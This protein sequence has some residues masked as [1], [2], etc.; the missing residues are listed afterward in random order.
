MSTKCNL[1]KACVLPFSHFNAYPMG[2]AR[3]CTM[4]GIFKDIDLNKVSID[5][6]FNSEEY[7]KLRS[8]MLNGIENDICKVCYN[9]E[10]RDSE[11]YRQKANNTYQKEYGLT[12][13]DLVVDIKE[14]GYL[15]PN[16]IKLDI[17]P[18]NICNFKCRTCSSEYSTR[19]IEEEREYNLSN[20]REF[21]E[22]MYK[23]IEKSY[24][25]SDDSII[26]LK[27][28][29][30]AGGESLY[31]T[32]MYKFLE[33]IK[34]K[35]KITLHI[36]TNLSL[37]K[38]KKY[39]IFELLKD[40]NTV[41]FFISCDGIGE[42]GE[43]IRTGFNWETFTKNV[44]KLLIM[45]DVYPNFK[46]NFHFTSSILNIFHFFEFLEEMKKRKYIKTD[47]QIQFY[48]VRWP[49]YFN[50]I[51]FNMKKEILEYYTSNINT[52]ESIELKTQIQNFIDYVDKVDMEQDWQ[53]LRNESGVDINAISTFKDMMDFG[54]KF[55]ETEIPE[56][57][58]YLKTILNQPKT[59]I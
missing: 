18:S 57:L 44:D 12:V 42:I 35:S 20:G 38:F 54:N 39:D 55:N 4:S 21:D 2:D 48:P 33:G 51:N 41:N 49:T 56:S 32:E 16:F 23:T 47:S 36:H 50:S 10:N 46:H 11:S 7:K 13:E 37:L 40:F 26:N 6:A 31:M 8:D 19:W 29:Y 52:I 45:E 24:G 14:D 17:R 43:Y 58:V 3:A 22:S 53:S 34:D 28:I 9:M 25:I 27:E 30:I 59:F 15:K 5:E 1:N